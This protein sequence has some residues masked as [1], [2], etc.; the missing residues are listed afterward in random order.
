MDRQHRIDAL[1][2]A[3]ASLGSAIAQT[4][5]AIR[6]STDPD[7]IERLTSQLA[8]LQAER[9]SVQFQLSNLEMAAGEIAAISVDNAAKVRTLSAD[10]DRAIVI[11]ATVS[12]TL[13]F[14]DI[15]LA[16]AS[17]MRRALA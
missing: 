1:R 17:E 10:L 9:Q 5:A 13:D 6:T 16:K 4:Q 3:L 14:A 11:G 2:K 12:A 7:E 8:D 15:V